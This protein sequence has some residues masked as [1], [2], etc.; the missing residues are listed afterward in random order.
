M[1]QV[2]GGGRVI[3]I[4]KYRWSIFVQMYSVALFIIG[5][6][7]GF[8]VWVILARQID[9]SYLYLGLVCVAIA[10]FFVWGMW[11]FYFQHLPIV[12]GEQGI[13]TLAFGRW[14]HLIPWHT[15]K[16]IE[17]MRFQDPMWG[18]DRAKFSVIA[19][20]DRIVFDD[21]LRELRGCLDAINEN[22][23][24]RSIELV[25]IDRGADTYE[26]TRTTVTNAEQRRKLMRDGVRVSLSEL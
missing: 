24:G 15:V 13:S 22:I 26:K 1:D 14:W 12:V 16:K 11:R 10:L 7:G 9:E 3:Q 8:G 6:I 23:R 20:D 17:K 5:V 21:G 18:M 25:F 2:G 4:W 19:P